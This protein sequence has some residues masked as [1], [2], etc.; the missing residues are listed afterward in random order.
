MREYIFD[1]ILV[2][3]IGLCVVCLLPTFCGPI[4]TLVF[5][6]IAVFCWW[7][8]CKRVLLLPLD[9]ILGKKVDLLYFSNYQNV[10]KLELFRNK[11]YFEWKF[12]THDKQS[13]VLI[14]PHVFPEENI[15]SQQSLA[16]DK[17]LEVHYYR[18][19]KIMVDCIEKKL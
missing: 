17:L 3:I 5:E 12:Y 1:Q 19:S 9:L 4:F 8:L 15:H 14:N 11:Y 16:E 10:D 6:M 7:M 2:L 18:L 13:V